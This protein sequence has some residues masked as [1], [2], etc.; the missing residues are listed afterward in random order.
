M[1]DLVLTGPY[2]VLHARLLADKHPGRNLATRA[3]T[4]ALQVA[5]KPAT[6]VAPA[7]AATTESLELTPMSA[8]GSVM[9]TAIAGCVTATATVLPRVGLSRRNLSCR[10]QN[11]T[12]TRPHSA[13]AVRIE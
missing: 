9:M 11:S 8:A 5:T 13:G 1:I 4:I 12:V 10:L 6:S 7:L 3:M 2:R